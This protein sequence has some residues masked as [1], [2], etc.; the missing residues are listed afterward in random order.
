MTENYHTPW[1]DGVTEFKADHMNVPLG[2]LDEEVGNLNIGKS[3]VGHVHADYGIVG[4]CVSYQS[5]DKP[6]SETQI[7]ILIVQKTRFPANLVGSYYYAATG[8]AAQAEVS[9]KRNGSQFATLTVG[10]SQTS[11]GT[12]AGS[13]TDFEAGDRLTLAYPAQDA[14]WAGVAITLK[15]IILSETT[16]TTTVASTTTTAVPT[17]TTVAPT[18]TTAAP[19]TT[20]T[21]APTTTTAAPT[22]TTTVAGTTT[23]TL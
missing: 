4:V 9:F 13:E 16:T 18:T 14:D 20:T 3:D 17:T 11:G 6:A 12:F 1:Q 23:T 2:E 19:G 22:T 15:G 5:G 7:H 10:A 8:P 21:A